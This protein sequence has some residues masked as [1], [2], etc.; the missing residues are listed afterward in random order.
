MG[1]RVWWLPFLGLA[2]C[3]GEGETEP[4]PP[5]PIAC[6]AP[7]L[8][9]PD[10][11]CIRPGVPVDGCAEGFTHDGEYGCEPVLPTAPCE[12]G[13]M[14]VPGDT[15][16][17]PV[18]ECGQGQWGDLPVDV[19]TQHVDASYTGATSDGSA[20]APW[21]T[22]GEAM[23]A[24]APGALVA[25][26][27]GTYS[28]SVIIQ[29]VPVRL[30]G[31]CPELVEIVG[32]ATAPAA[33]RVLAP[34]SELGG[35]A[36]RGPAD[37]IG[38][39]GADVT[40]DRVWLHNTGSLGIVVSY[41]AAPATVS[42]KGSLIEGSHEFGVALIGSTAV[43]EKSLV[44]GTAP[45]GGNI[46]GQG[47]HLQPRCSNG[48]CDPATRANLTLLGSLIEQNQKIGVSIGAGD[49]TVEG[50]VVRT[51]T[52]QAITNIGGRGIAAED[53]GP[54]QGCTTRS[55]ANLTLRGS[56]VEQNTEIGIAVAGSDATIESTVVR[57][58]LPRPTDGL[59]G[60][61]VRIQISCASL[62]CDTTARANGTLRTSVIAANHEQGLSILGADGVVED[63][64]V[65]DTQPRASDQYMG[66][67][68]D[69]SIGCFG[70]ECDTSPAIVTLRRMLI[71]R[72]HETG[73]RVSASEALVESSIIRDTRMEASNVRFGDGLAVLSWTMQAR[74]TIAGI[75]SR[76]NARAGVANFGAYASID[77]S[78]LVCNGFDLNGDPFMDLPFAFEDRGNNRCGCPEAREAC[79]ASSSA[80]EAPTDLAGLD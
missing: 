54:A 49:A 53:C 31:V 15:A 5:P 58:T 70:N 29:A 28:E 67:G 69:V 12:P 21:K 3:A 14:A 42:I 25:V 71:E 57:G 55:R 72:N 10:G 73:A 1:P 64:V 17:R 59:F 75:E 38:T 4:P 41:S 78:S 43:I 40:I 24:A 20:A 48:V 68:V 27:A 65:R 7:E 35:V 26:A 2:G 79:A 44:R 19:T 11:S 34:G 32:S 76:A 74:L 9:L 80:L 63:T 62:P 47:V 56:L 23:A 8:A 52:P 61:G 60:V 45:G 16:C 6:E 30:W 33:V 66:R 37:G 46:G 51:T 13:R 39:G 22:I 50:S 36:I 18:M 77:A